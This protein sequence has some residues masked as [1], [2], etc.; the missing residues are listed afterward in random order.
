MILVQRNA[1]SAY[2]RRETKPS[3]DPSG[4]RQLG[5][6]MYRQRRHATVSHSTDVLSVKWRVN[7]RRNGSLLLTAF[8]NSSSCVCACAC[9]CRHKERKCGELALPV[10]GRERACF[11]FLAFLEYARK[12]V[13]I[14]LYSLPPAA[15]SGS[16]KKR[17][18]R[19]YTRIRVFSKKR[20]KE[21]IRT[22]T[23]WELTESWLCLI[24]TPR[25]SVLT[26]DT[27]NAAWGTSGPPQRPHAQRYTIVLLQ[28]RALV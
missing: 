23:M 17:G 7:V 9:V 3:F 18:G 26:V 24:P 13:I 15:D 27:D 12:R 11:I 16:P 21:R 22:C 4:R 19:K 1:S 28:P 10:T 6:R 8:N 5:T 14:T 25:L 20:E 2:S